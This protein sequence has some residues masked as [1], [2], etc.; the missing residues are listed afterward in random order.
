M[1]DPLWQQNA[2]AKGFLR[3]VESLLPKPETPDGK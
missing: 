2:E 1:K 3:E